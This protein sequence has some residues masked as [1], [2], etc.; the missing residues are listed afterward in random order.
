MVA[1]VNEFDKI[2]QAETSRTLAARGGIILS[3]TANTVLVDGTGAGTPS[4]ITLKATPLVV[5]GSVTWATSPTVPLTIDST[6]LIA[7]LHFADMGS[8]SIAV[9]V[10]LVSN[11]L[12]YTDSKTVGQVRIG[13][14]GYQGALD[15][16]RN[17]TAQGLL[18]ARPAG[19]DGDFYFATDALTLY[20]KLSGTWQVAGNNFT[21]TNQLTDGANLGGTAVWTGV[22]GTGKPS[23]N[24][25]ADLVLTGRG[26]TVVG[27]TLTRTNAASG[28]WDADAYSQDSFTGG[29]FASATAVGTTSLMFGLNSDPVTDANYTSLDYAIYLRVDNAVEVYESNAASGALTTYVAGDVFAVVYDGSSVRYLKNG[30]VFYTSNSAASRVPG[31]R[32]F[33]D[34]SFNATGSSI[35]NVRFGPLTSNNWADVGG[36]GKPADNASADLV[37]IGRGVVVTGNSATK[38]SGNP[39]W[40]SDAYSK[41]SFTGGAYASIAAADTTSRVMFGLNS[42]PV[43]DSSYSSLDY[44]LY[45]DTT[46]TPLVVSVYESGTF[47]ASFGA[48]VAGDVY[49]ILYDGSSVKYLKNGAVFYT[50]TSTTAGN[51]NQT[52]FFDSS[53]FNVGAVMKNIR[54]G[55][56]SSNNWTSIGG[57]GKPADNA[58]SDLVLIGRNVTVTGNSGVKTGGSNGLWDADLYSKDSFTGGAF[59]SASPAVATDSMMFGLNSDP[60]TDSSYTSIDYAIYLDGGTSSALRVYEG[61]SLAGTFGTYAAGDVLAVVYDGSSV[62]YL[63]NGAVVYTSI[64]AAS[65]QPNQVLYFDSSFAN[66]NG[67]LNNIRFGPLSSNNWL[68]IGGRP[69]DGNN[70][71]LKPTFEDGAIGDWDGGPIVTVT[72]QAFTKALQVSARDSYANNSGFPVNVGE[73]LYAEAWLD[74]STANYTLNFGLYFVKADGTY[75]TWIAMV[76]RNA[77]SGWAFGAGSCTVPANAVKAYPW[78]QISGS[79]SLGTGRATLLRV[80]RF[81]SGATVGATLGSN[82]NGQITGSNASS[83]MNI[84]NLGVMSSSGTFRTASSGGRVEIA[85]NVI[86][87]YDSSN[88][89]RVKI[90]NL[91]L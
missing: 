48:W 1:P 89:L 56:L 29:A 64:L 21:N 45:F 12:T 69:Q 65:F 76:A 26:V 85:D 8:S 25:S 87:V 47:K 62:K 44:A 39:N 28:N 66:L 35:R 37:L 4:I 30:A 72:G 17:N 77:G 86:K 15:A 82:V 2:L 36:T 14:L 11:G 27:N 58:S 54:F 81:Q 41:D 84:P 23:D 40:D 78:V 90:G 31:Q 19:A 80:S 50:S 32:L 5:A 63:K 55:P 18:S 16:T 67:K 59:A 46:T 79:S 70:L 75:V 6:G 83:L 74:A 57:I 60:V 7:T 91:S 24:A 34:S 52:F 38:A 61:G 42:D 71:V 51:P 20:Q 73:T 10:T 3:T 88:G 13:S 53:F 22:S 43:T 9:T 33:F 49:A 68:T